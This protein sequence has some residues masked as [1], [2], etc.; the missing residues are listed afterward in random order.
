AIVGGMQRADGSNRTQPAPQQRDDQQNTPLSN[1]KAGFIQQKKMQLKIKLSQKDDDT[2]HTDH[3]HAVV[4]QLVTQQTQQQTQL[5]AGQIAPQYAQRQQDQQHD[6]LIRHGH[7][8][9]TGRQPCNTD[10]QQGKHQIAQVN[11]WKRG[12]QLPFT[13][14]HGQHGLPFLQA[15]KAVIGCSRQMYDIGP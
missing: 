1:Q 5:Y 11:Q 7:A 4:T 9:P 2:D 12:G 8:A 3:Q 15:W 6:G 13:K 14:D 10:R